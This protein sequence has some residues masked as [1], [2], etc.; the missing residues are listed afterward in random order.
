MCSIGQSFQ[1]C[2]SVTLTPSEI[3][4]LTV[5]VGGCLKPFWVV[6]VFTKEPWTRK[7]AGYS[8]LPSMDH[9][10]SFTQ[11]LDSGCQDSGYDHLLI[12][13]SCPLW[14]TNITSI[15]CTLYMVITIH[16]DNTGTRTSILKKAYTIGHG[17][18]SKVTL[19]TWYF[20]MW[21]F[22]QRHIGIVWCKFISVESYCH[23]PY[24]WRNNIM[25]KYRIC[26]I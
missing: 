6:L 4:I 7:Q 23:E 13:Y 3:R 2:T 17:T 19:W 9:L 24:C 1:S 10:T 18:T 5:D 20:F 25:S 16:H 8:W 14:H 11:R 21:Y 26:I 22:G 12:E 15:S